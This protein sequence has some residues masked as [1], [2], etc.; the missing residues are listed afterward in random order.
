MNSMTMIAV[1]SNASDAADHL[2]AAALPHE[3]RKIT[4]R[5]RGLDGRGNQD[6]TLM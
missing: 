2:L 3:G 5:R 4:E 6:I 1:T